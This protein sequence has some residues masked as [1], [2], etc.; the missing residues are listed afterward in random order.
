M[1]KQIVG[2][3]LKDWTGISVS[4]IIVLFYQLLHEALRD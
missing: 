3:V 1:I 4:V 2:G